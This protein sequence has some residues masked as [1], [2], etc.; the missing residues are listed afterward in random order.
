MSEHYVGWADDE[1]HPL[2]QANL[3]TLDTAAKFAP[4][5]IAEFVTS[6]DTLSEVLFDNIPIG[7]FHHIEVRFSGRVTGTLANRELQCRL[8]G[9][10]GNN[11]ERGS[12]SL[13]FA[14]GRDD[15]FFPDTN[16]AA[17]GRVSVGR[18]STTASIHAAQGLSSFKS[19]H[20]LSHVRQGGAAS[21]NWVA[22]VSGRW[23]STAD[24]TSIAIRTTQTFEPL[25]MFTLVGYFEVP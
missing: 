5:I 12:V 18:S 19:I 17:I 1:T 24:I 4:Q 9:D 22:L 6:D 10:T 7:P 20:G 2:S 15:S 25:S 3:K 16:Q 13:D 21:T 11:Y 8:N 23:E 14:A